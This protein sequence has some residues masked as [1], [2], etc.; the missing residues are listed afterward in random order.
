MK[1][2]LTVSVALLV[3]IASGIASLFIAN[4]HSM[5]DGGV[6]NQDVV[7]AISLGVVALV[8][9]FILILLEYLEKDNWKITRYLN[10]DNNKNKEM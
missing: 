4:S 8:F 3:W 6:L 1:I 9:V 7:L 5:L 10:G 2:I